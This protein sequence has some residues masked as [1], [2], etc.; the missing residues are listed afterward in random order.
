MCMAPVPPMRPK[1]EE[2][3]SKFG[4]PGSAADGR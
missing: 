3:K 2:L 1:V 4:V